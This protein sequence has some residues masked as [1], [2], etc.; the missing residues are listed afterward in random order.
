MIPHYTGNIPFIDTEQMVEADRRAIDDYGLSLIQMMENAGLNLALVAKT[1]FL[2]NEL[3][4]KKVIVIA[5]SGGN[6][7][8]AMAAARRLKLWGADVKVILSSPKGKFIKETIDQFSILQNIGI[9][10]I[11][12][13]EAVDLIIDGMIGYSIKGDPAGKAA[14][15]IHR[16]NESK[17]PVL[18]LDAPSG[19]N[20]TTGKPGKPTIKAKAT[21]TLGLPKVGLFKLYASKLIGDLYLAD[22]SIPPEVYKDFNVDLKLIHKA[23]KENTV[24]KINKVVVF[25]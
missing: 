1:V 22:I 9:G 14:E 6:G 5:G 4:D 2:K 21:M 16:V 23:F 25:N 18:A 24:V 17:I 12:E 11:H 13:L 7:G 20:L 10:I 8:G 15:Y 3:Q 19:L